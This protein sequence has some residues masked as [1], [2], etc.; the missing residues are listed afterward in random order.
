MKYQEVMHYLENAM[1]EQ[2]LRAGSKLPSISVLAEELNGSYQTVKKAYDELIDHHMAYKIEHSGY[3]LMKGVEERL[4]SKQVDLKLSGMR[5]VLDKHHIHQMFGDGWSKY[6]PEDYEIQGYLPLRQRLNRYFRERKIFATN[7]DIIVM[8]TMK[9]AMLSILSQTSL[10][11]VLIESSTDKRLVELFKRR[12]KISTFSFDGFDENLLELRIIQEKIKLIVLTPLIHLP[13]GDTLDLIDR[14]KLLEICQRH[15]VYIVEL[16]Q[17][18]DM[19]DYIESQSLFALDRHNLVFHMKTFDYVLSS[20]LKTVVLIAP[21]QYTEKILY[22]KQKYIGRGTV[23]EEVVLS[24]F[25]E[26][27]GAF[28]KVKSLIHQ[29]FKKLQEA[30]VDLHVIASDALNFIFVQVPFHSNLETVLLELQS[31]NI[32]LENVSDYFVDDHEFKGYIVSV[33]HVEERELCKSI[34]IIKSHFGY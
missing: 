13:T 2:T 26:K 8:P 5:K 21:R 1:R 33:G 4:L 19:T 28:D 10:D 22:Y 23:F 14:L 30:F 7:H 24:E 6:L 27:Q 3:Y 12:Q 17:F 34:E 31:H 18:E 11:A 15:G 32:Y 9:Q 20:E 16:N 25:F 29:N